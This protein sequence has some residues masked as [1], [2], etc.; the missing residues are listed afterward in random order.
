VFTVGNAYQL[1]RKEIPTFSV[2]DISSSLNFTL[3]AAK[4]STILKTFQR[5]CLSENALIRSGNGVQANKKYGV[6]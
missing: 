2:K 3:L 6:K 1:A 5:H 4:F